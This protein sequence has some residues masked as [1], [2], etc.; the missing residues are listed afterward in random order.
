MLT[1][2]LKASVTNAGCVCGVQDRMRLASSDAPGH[3]TTSS[4][5]LAEDISLLL[6]LTDSS[7]DLLFIKHLPQC[8]STCY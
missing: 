6:L 1:L 4:P 7:S 3:P 2:L 8:Q 5:P